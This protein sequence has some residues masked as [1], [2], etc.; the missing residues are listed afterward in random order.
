M[1]QLKFGMGNKNFKDYIDQYTII[2]LKNITN[3]HLFHDFVDVLDIC[4]FK[5][6]LYIIK[7]LFLPCLF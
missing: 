3:T 2:Y 5:N 4:F 7:E 6:N 1:V